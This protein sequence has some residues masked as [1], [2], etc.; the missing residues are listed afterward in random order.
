MRVIQQSYMSSIG[1]DFKFDLIPASAGTFFVGAIEWHRASLEA[2]RHTATVFKSFTS[3]V[4]SLKL[5]GTWGKSI[6]LSDGLKPSDRFNGVLNILALF[7]LFFV[8]S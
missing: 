6:Q 5:K 3:I 7:K 4:L 1:P 8:L 2:S